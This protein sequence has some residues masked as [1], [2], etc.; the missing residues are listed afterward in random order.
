MGIDSFRVE[1]KVY[2]LIDFSFLE[3]VN[4]GTKL[5]NP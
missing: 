3:T 5:M 2:E 4:V 1:E